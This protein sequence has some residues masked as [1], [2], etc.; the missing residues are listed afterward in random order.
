[1]LGTPVWGPRDV[2][3]D[4]EGNIYLAD[5]GV[6]KLDSTGQFVT[7]F[8]PLS[9][10]ASV[11]ALA[12][13]AAGNVYTASVGTSAPNDLIRKHSPDGQLL[14]HCGNNGYQP[15]QISIVSSLCVGPTGIIYVAD[16]N[17]RRLF[18]FDQ[19]GTLLPEISLPSMPTST[20]LE[21]V[22]VD[23]AGNLYLLYDNALVTK[24][25]PSGQLLARISL[26]NATG[27]YLYNQAKVLLLDAAGNLLVSYSQAGIS[28]YSPS[29][30]LLGTISQ[31]FSSSTHTAMAFDQAGNLYATDFT[32]Q[33]FQN[34]LYKFA[35]VSTLRQRWGNLTSLDYVRQDEAGNTF[36]YDGSTVRKYNAGG[37]LTLS[38]NASV[39][40]KYVGGFAV[41]AAGTIYVLGTSDTSSEL[42][43]YTAQGQQVQRLTSF[44]FTQGYQYF[45]GLAVGANGTIYLSDKYGHRIRRL[46]SQGVL[47]GT[48]GG[49][50]LGTGQFLQPR[51][52]AVDWAGNVYVADYDGKRVQK[53]N[54]QGQ[55]MQ[56][57][58]PSPPYNGI[59]VGLVDLDVDG[60]GNVYVA[61]FAHEGKIFSAD[62]SRET[63]MP[64]YGTAVSVNRS[65]TRLLSMRSGSDVV[66]FFGS[67]QQPP[68]NL[69]SG[70]LY[71]DLNRNCQR[72]SNEPVLSNMAVVAEPG[73]Y[74]G[75]TDEN[76]SYVLAVDT[77]RYQVRP[78]LPPEEV[79]RQVQHSCSP[80]IAIAL[81]T[82]NK[83]V[84]KVDFGLQVSTSPFLR[85]SI[86]SNRRRR[87]FRNTTTVAY[88][89][90]GY[91]AAADV[92]VAVAF[93]PEVVV[94]SANQPYTRDTRGHYLFQVGSLAAGA[95]GTIVL[96]DSVV[97]GIP[98]LRGQT[99]CTEATITPRN[100]YPV[101]PTWSQASV[102]VQGK[103]EPGNQVRFVVRNTAATTMSDSA[104]LRLYQDGELSLL[105]QYQL[106]AGDSLVLR[107]P[108]TRPVVRL[109]ADQPAGHPTQRVASQTVEVRTLS[110]PGQANANMRSQP[111]NEPGPETAQDCQPILDSYD[112]N[113]KLVVPTGVTAQ[114]FTPTN[115]PLRYQIRFQNT[116]TDDAYRVEVVDTLAAELDLRTLRVSAAS[117][118][119]RLSVRGHGRP[120]L[121]FTFDRLMLPPSSRDAVG[122]NGF[123][124][125]SV[126]PK[127][128]LAP[129][130]KVENF[131]D[132]FFDYN[133]PVRT[134]T[135]VNRIYDVPLV[136]NPAVQVQAQNVLVS[137]SLQAFVP[138][139][140]R[141]GTLVTLSGQ[142]FGPTAAA[143]RI[144]FNGVAAPVLTATA[145]SLTVRVPAGATPGPIE[146][147]TADGAT[148]SREH[149]V[150]YQPP[151][152]T[153]MQPSEGIVG[154]LVT[155]I[156][157]HF[158]SLASQDTV[159][160]NGIPALVQYASMTSLQVIVPAGATS[161]A[162]QLRT[163][164]GGVTSA[165][166]F[167]VWSAPTLTS[168]SPARGKVGDLLTITGTHFA[169]TR[170]T[171]S[172]AGG[173]VS[174]VQATSTRLQV[175]VPVD[176]QT[177]QIRVTTPG[178][179]A[180]STA[181]FTFLPPPALTSFSPAQGSV[182]EVITLTGSNF[183]VEGH[184]DTVYIG[185]V[186]AAIL[187]TTATS[188]TVR[189]PRGASSGP[190][191]IAGTGG[192]VNSAQPFTVLDLSP[193]EALRVYP[194]PAPG[195]VILEWQQANFTLDQVHVYN[196]LGKLLFTTTLSQQGEPQQ[197]L[198]F[199]GN[200][201]GLFLLVVHTSR[202]PVTKKII[203]Y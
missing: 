89:N 29:G 67:A 7:S 187:A 165:Q 73:G 36:T 178:G 202:G 134:N 102:T 101:P 128:G 81:R 200:P 51:A 118:P 108:A 21:D 23:A 148:R 163:L 44:G 38:F 104:A 69:I 103:A 107:V 112:P 133:E 140:G 42:I 191:T 164:G 154:S 167:T 110:T 93:P 61:S 6:T 59:S 58:G 147:V 198:T 181:A 142:R 76:G 162:I 203:L 94:V 111:P 30:T 16:G 186:Q 60:R 70:Q 114:H 171:V 55:V 122:S 100:S 201:S 185:D 155:L 175:R 26:G 3:V 113:D 19:Q 193:A 196:A 46:T 63:P 17:N 160:F 56:Q 50:G 145:T 97:C 78:L 159:W 65:A 24:L 130:T 28:R 195:A 143:N 129:Q 49:P 5:G 194:S 54:A 189:V 25:S 168:F 135:T 82:Y 182:G 84:N 98:A 199:A 2:A 197:E 149:F 158:S 87:C 39:G 188:V 32:H 123:V 45:N 22:D 43:K 77:G 33:Q 31:R 47:M 125:F 85:V 141:A 177:G 75:M 10:A 120:V 137:P 53:F 119:Y 109:E 18:R 12:L 146:I 144:R 152:L 64:S 34:H 66:Q 11:E 174:L 9:P 27:G 92:A 4:R 156:G 105:H 139:Q 157:T 99:V 176:A 86:A 192:R 173:T 117:H 37:Q 71:H 41:D 8:K 161:G 172:L 72:E 116:G 52:V 74:Y 132:I 83:V 190:W 1:M 124:Q 170:T 169:P 15:G 151:T 62:G 35:G 184:L 90:D 115:T 131:A 179:M 180:Q 13:D 57:F 88:R 127:A 138:A 136:V 95:A 150:A 79:G 153:A 96:Q 68:T 14:M 106:A 183:L 91:A 48:I 80:A 20:S 166:P 40:G 121:T 126:Q